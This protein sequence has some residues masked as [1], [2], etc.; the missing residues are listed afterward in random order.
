MNREP[1]IKTKHHLP[2]WIGVNL[3]DV[4]VQ[5]ALCLQ[6]QFPQT[7]TQSPSHT[8]VYTPTHPITLTL[9]PSTD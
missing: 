7:Y 2:D 6:T 1:T 3:L 8:Q 9:D 4:Q 5:A